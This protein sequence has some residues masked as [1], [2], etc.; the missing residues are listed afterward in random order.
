M[1][2]AWGI[3]VS[4]AELVQKLVNT[5]LRIE[6]V[7]LMKKIQTLEERAVRQGV[8]PKSFKDLRKE[9]EKTIPLSADRIDRA[10]VLPR[11]PEGVWRRRY[12]AV[13]QKPGSVF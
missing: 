7:K 1:T 8:S 11:K 5:R 6:R 9:L 13:R 12:L 3:D 4:V 2:M 10:L